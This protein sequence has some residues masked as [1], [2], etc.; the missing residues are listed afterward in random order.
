MSYYKA[1]HMMYLL[2][3]E[4]EQM[5]KDARAWYGKDSGK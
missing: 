4:L 1:G 5:K 2:K 3:S